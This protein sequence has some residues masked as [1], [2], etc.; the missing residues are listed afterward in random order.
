[1]KIL[2]KNGRVV[3]PGSGLDETFDV[4]V[5][6]GRIADLKP[7][8]DLA[9]DRTI[10]ASRLGSF[11]FSGFSTMPVTCSPSAAMEITP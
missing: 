4:L 2:I 3:D 10:D 7:T 6:D 8:I 5:V 9:V 1:M 11:R